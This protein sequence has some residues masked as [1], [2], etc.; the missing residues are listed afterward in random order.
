MLKS[1]DIL[2]ILKCLEVVYNIQVNT[3]YDGSYMVFIA[4]QSSEVV[5]R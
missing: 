2:L 5:T 3:V 4:V 1:V